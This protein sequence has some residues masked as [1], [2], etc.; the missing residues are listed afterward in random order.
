MCLK[1]K[2]LPTSLQLLIGS[3]GGGGGGLEGVEGRGKGLN[4]RKSLKELPLTQL[5]STL[6]QLSSLSQH[7]GQ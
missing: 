6:W 7:S 2:L 3:P 4:D 1:Y 5:Y